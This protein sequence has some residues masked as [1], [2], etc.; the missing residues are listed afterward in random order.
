MLYCSSKI[1]NQNI[2]IDLIANDNEIEVDKLDI[3]HIDDDLL[4]N[5]VKRDSNWLRRT[6]FVKAIQ[7]IDYLKEIVC[8]DVDSHVCK[9]AVEKIHDES[10]LKDLFKPSNIYSN[11]IEKLCE[12]NLIKAAAHINEGGIARNVLRVVPNWDNPQITLF[13]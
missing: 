10:F 2:A 11:V 6:Y 13:S 5:L 9:V 7:N 3:Q 1:S 8:N 4:F 12:K